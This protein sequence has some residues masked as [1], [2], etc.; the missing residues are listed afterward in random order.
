MRSFLVA[1]SDSGD[2]SFYVLK[3]SSGGRLGK[4]GYPTEYKK[5]SNFPRGVGTA[6]DQPQS[7]PV[8]LSKDSHIIPPVSTKTLNGIIAPRGQVTGRTP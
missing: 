4:I 2:L 1:F 8:A 5:T 7:K 3:K 6:A